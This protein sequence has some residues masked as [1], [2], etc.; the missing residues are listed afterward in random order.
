MAANI[1]QV[2]AGMTGSIGFAVLFGIRGKK[3]ITIAFGGAL[4]WAVY[5]VCSNC[6]IEMYMS[7]FA[8][9]FIVAS[10]SAIMARVVKTPVLVLMVP[11]TIPMI[12]GGDLYY[13]MYY[14]VSRQYSLFNEA[15]GKVM[16]EALSMAL[17]IAVSSYLVRLILKIRK[18]RNTARQGNRQKDEETEV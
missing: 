3:I 1:I 17:G 4:G 13:T 7:L 9:T 8:G 5:L 15:S 6:G 2:L 10:F 11:M 16:T 14:L 12:P 18:Q